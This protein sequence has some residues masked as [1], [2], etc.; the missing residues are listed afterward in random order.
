MAKVRAVGSDARLLAG[1]EATYGIAPAAFTKVQF[2]T[3]D[4]SEE[5]SL[6]EDPLLGEGRDASDPF[7]NRPTDAG[8]F[9][10][11]LDVRGSGFWLR[12]I[13]G[14]PVT[15]DNLDGTYTHVFTAGGDLPS[16]H[17]EIGHPKL[18]TPQYY[19][20]AGAKLGGLTFELTDNGP[21]NGQVSVI[22]QSEIKNGATV[23][24]TPDTYIL[25]RFNQSGGA[26]KIDGSALGHVTGGSFS[27]DNSLEAITTIRDD[28][29]IDG[30]DE[31]TAKTSGSV[32]V[33]H[34]TDATLIDAA[35][36]ETPVG[37][38]YSFTKA[39][40]SGFSI[41][42]SMPRVFL[43]KPKK[44]I[45]GPGGIDLT[46]DWQASKDDTA[47]HALQITLLNDVESY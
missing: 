27:F 24:A 21:A 4:L 13:F 3:S 19:L 15:T 35:E 37:L 5:K 31:G 8:N 42:F 22:A 43:K 14:D 33:R 20:H 18:T 29:L 17:F 46:I 40:A 39:G 6:G 34:S 41:T 1:F 10:I 26:I 23:D 47:G 38:D 36:N 16:M 28:G 2:K 7:Y 12:G 9:D 25:D 44:S 32:T 11:P 30:V 45:S